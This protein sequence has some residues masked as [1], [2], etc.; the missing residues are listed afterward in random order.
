MTKRLAWVAL[1]GIGLTCPA[2]ANED[3]E[4]SALR[5]QM[6]EAIRD[7][8]QLIHEIEGV[9]EVDGP[10]LEVMARVP[11]HRFVPEPLR[12]LAYHNRPLPVGQGQNIAQPYLIALMTSLARVTPSDIV[13]ETG[14]GA[15]YHA[16]VLAELAS[17]V[18][19][20]EV[21]DGLAIR[22]A[23]VLGE[24]GYHN[25]ETRIG[26]GYFGWPEKGPFDVIIVKEAI[27]HVPPPLLKQLKPGGR[28]VAPV[29]P[30]R[31]R[32]SLTLIEKDA[33]GGITTTQILEVRFTPLQGGQR[34]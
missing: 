26:D 19:S 18:Y 34:I 3:A 13:F 33:N 16:A 12:P 14:T 30:L 25:V 21:V 9:P 17:R 4:F 2:G 23:R 29:G 27:D 24:L 8:A 10:V 1:L 5:G 6:V 15:G 32:Q 20:V 11:R 28:L 7:Y 31:D 22:A